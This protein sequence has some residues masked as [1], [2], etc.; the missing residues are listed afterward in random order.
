MLQDGAVHIGKRL[1]ILGAQGIDRVDSV[2]TG[3]DA[4]WV[5][6]GPFTWA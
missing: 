3:Y 4:P 1:R 2:I 5:T 6:S